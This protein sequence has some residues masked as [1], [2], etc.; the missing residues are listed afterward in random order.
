MVIGNTL[1]SFCTTQKLRNT[2]RN[3]EAA[4]I[5]YLPMA[6]RLHH[7]PDQH[8][9][10]GKRSAVSPPSLARCNFALVQV[11]RVD[12]FVLALQQTC[13]SNRRPFHLIVLSRSPYYR[14]DRVDGSKI[15]VFLS[16][17]GN[18]KDKL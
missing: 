6:P 12:G 8:L 2:L 15:D 10:L 1:K 18:I 7:R 16:L 9:G 4:K 17:S 13:R 5:I 11:A 3:K 14:T